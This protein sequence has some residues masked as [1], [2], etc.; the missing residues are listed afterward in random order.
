MTVL[1]I[2]DEEMIRDLAQKILMRA[3]FDVLSAPTGQ[4][5]VQL[6]AERYSQIDLVLLDLTMEDMPGL[7]TLKKLRE[8]SPD[9]PCLISSGHA[10]GG[11]ELPEELNHNVYFL[12]K[13]YRANQLTEAV[14]Q[15]LSRVPRQSGQ[16][17]QT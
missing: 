7:E 1:I 4:S 14:N 11:Y 6:Y 3:G 5:G 15:M 2:D 9:L 8:V 10:P 17:Q 13:P 12:Q 16:Y